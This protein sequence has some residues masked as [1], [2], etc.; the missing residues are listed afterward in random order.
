MII[1]PFPPAPELVAHALD[2]LRALHLGNPA[3][4]AALGPGQNLARPWEPATCSDQMRAALWWW[5]DDVVA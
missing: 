2:Q 1:A 3:A 5:C 4:V